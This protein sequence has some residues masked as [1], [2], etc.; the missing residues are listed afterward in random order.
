MAAFHLGVVRLGTGIVCG[1]P[2]WNFA[3]SETSIL[4]ESR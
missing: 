1:T 4:A 2:K 3:I